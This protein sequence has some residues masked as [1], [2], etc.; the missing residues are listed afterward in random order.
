M[1][2]CKTWPYGAP[3]VRKDI[4]EG[5]KAGVQGTPTFFLGIEE[6]DSQTVK[7]VRKIVGAQPYSQFKQAIE[8]A[9]SQ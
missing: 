2:H 5:L 4:D 3:G 8:A 1:C 7:V 9:F 6:P